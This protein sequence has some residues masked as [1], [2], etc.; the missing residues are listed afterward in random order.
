MTRTE[1]V[2]ELAA[3]YTA[4]DVFVNATLEDN[5]PTTN[6]EAQ[7]CGTPVITFDTGGSSES[8]PTA[9]GMVVPKGDYRALY[10]AVLQMTKEGKR[11]DMCLLMR[12]R[13]DQ[14]K[15]FEAYMELYKE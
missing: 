12:D 2:E 7:A 15:C 1:S 4:A 9:C 13:Y 6:M 10:K 8:V 5:Y 3:F 14:K 11:T